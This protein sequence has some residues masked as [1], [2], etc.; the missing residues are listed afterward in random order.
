MLMNKV[1]IASVFLLLLLSA[2]RATWALA[3]NNIPLDSPIYLYLDKLGGFGLIVTD[4][5]GL[6][7]Y[8]RAEAAR[9]L[10]EAEHSVATCAGVVE[11][12]AED[13]IIR[14]RELLHREVLL[15]E[16]AAPPTSDYDFFSAARL[17]YVY[18]DGVPRSYNRDIVDPGHQSVFGFIG[19]DLRNQGPD[20]VHGTGAEGTP[21]FENNEG[22]IYRQGSNGEFRWDM[23]AFFMDKVSVLLEPQIL[24]SSGS[25]DLTLQKGYVK[26]GGGGLELEV[27]RDAL[28]FG[29]GYRGTTTLTNNAQNFDMIKLSS[30]E[31]V[32]TTWAKKYLGD[33]KYTL[34]FARFD[35]TGY[36]EGHRQPYF[37]GLK[38]DVKPTSW[39]EMGF[40]MVR[41]QGGPG[42]PGN[43]ST[44]CKIFG[45]CSNDGINAI[46]GFDMR[47]RLP[48][49]RN[50]EIYGEFSG[51]DSASFWPFVES[52][53][54][55]AYIPNLT[56]SGKDDLRLEA[57][58]GSYI[59]YVDYQFPNGYNYHGMTPGHS[60]GG[61]TFD[62]FTEYTHWFSVRNRVALDYFFT[63]RGNGGRMPDQAVERKN[64]GRL[65]WS[66]PVV[67]DINAKLMYGI[68]HIY[69]FNLVGGSNRTNQ[70]AFLELSY[71]Y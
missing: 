6:R 53:I 3:S 62:F 58:W 67:G 14:L 28:W 59:A 33:F 47:F 54:V 52:Y 43:I 17:R 63:E 16:G 40:N 42:L 12:F 45:G 20:I 70:L 29:P 68:E 46:A 4:T 71:K 26:L 34:A 24:V 39:F 66:L 13:L 31:P 32:D 65:W 35:S 50:T 55:G 69:N 44:F 7:P 64:A 15:R 23:D 38:L 57:Y 61:A 5:K 60:Q 2:P 48:W 36:G 56:S 21:L 10:L 19:G 27:G 9:L 11:P 8:S 25:Q 51:E 41:E 22:V 1:I 37:V 49:L 18:L 30:P